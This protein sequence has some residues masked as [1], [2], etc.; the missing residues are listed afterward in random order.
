MVINGDGGGLIGCNTGLLQGS[1]VSPILFLIYIA[2]LPK[3][4]EK[5]EKNVLNLSFVDDVT[6]AA[7][8]LNV[9][10]VTIPAPSRNTVGTVIIDEDSDKSAKYS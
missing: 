5:A 7:T 10:E 4:V 3:V 2:D 6:W 1:P 8:G 9:D